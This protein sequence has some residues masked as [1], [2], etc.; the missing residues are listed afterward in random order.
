MQSPI[1]TILAALLPTL[2]TVAAVHAQQSRETARIATALYLGDVPTIVADERNLFSGQ[3]VDARITRLA[4]GR[5][6]MAKL[7]AGEADFALMALTPFVL[8]RLADDDP[9]E[10]DD[11]VILANLVHS[12]DLLQIVSLESAG[13]RQAEDLRGHRIAVDR[14]TNSEFVW[15]LQEQFHGIE[16]SGIELVDL[17]FPEMPDALTA[18]RIDAAVLWEPWVSKL[19]AQLAAASQP[20]VVHFHV[21]NLYAGKWVLV[22]TRGT[23]DDRRALCRAVLEAYQQAIEFV[24]RKPQEAIA[25]FNRRMDLAEGLMDDHWNALDYNLN[26]DWG[27]IADL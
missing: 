4:S 26:L 27:L 19:D 17:P 10:P 9:G 11:P 16:R 14:G 13:I 7:R 22:T 5:Q 18:G 21:N 23:A 1:K 12:T 24:D 20:G 2:L 6:S 3:G 15:W 8:D 25:M